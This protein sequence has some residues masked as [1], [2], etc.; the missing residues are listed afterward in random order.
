MSTLSDLLTSRGRD[1]FMAE[2]LTNA[3]D[4]GLATTSWQPG[5][6]VRTILAIV[7]QS[8]ATESEVNVEPVKGGFG[9]LQSSIGW[10]RLWSKQTYNVDAVLAQPATGYIDA[11]NTSSTQYDIDPGDLIVAH[12]TTGKTYRNVEA[13]S[14]PAN[15]SLNNIAIMATEV[16]TGSNAAATFVTVVIAPSMDGVT[17]SN[18][19]AVLGSDDEGVTALVTR[20]RESQ[21]AL[22][23]N[24]PK[25]AYNYVVK[26][27]ELCAT[28]QPITRAATVAN[29]ST[30][31][32]TVYVATASGAPEASDVAICQTALDKSAEPWCVTATAVA[33]TPLVIPVTYEV[34]VRSQKTEAEIKSLIATALSEFFAAQD[35][36]GTILPP[37]VGRVYG[38]AVNVAIATTEGA[39]ILR[40][41][42]TMSDIDGDGDEDTDVAV[43]EVPVLGTVTGTVHFL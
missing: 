37:D 6:V 24:G 40:A 33:A 26:T 17:I 2:L 16:G 13:I 23:P 18:P 36:G 38:S 20:S 31:A 1:A 25:D 11:T 39:G 8:L 29:P 9:D 10:T 43:G 15:G 41:T 12:S 32:V 30:G 3:A 22:S 19:E 21:G 27:P 34:W 5:S 35:V 42:V 14:I 28:G 4:L 7:A